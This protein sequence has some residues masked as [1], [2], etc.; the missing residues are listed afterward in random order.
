MLDTHWNSLNQ[1]K[2]TTFTIL[3]CIHYLLASRADTRSEFILEA[4]EMISLQILKLFLF[5]TETGLRCSEIGGNVTGISSLPLGG[6]T[7]VT[8]LIQKFQ[9]R[10]YYKVLDIT[11]FG[12]NLILEAK[13]R[14]RLQL[15]NRLFYSAE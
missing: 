2:V 4:V 9:Q 1:Y 12:F 15:E 6:T 5:G 7:S 13:L 3:Q 10:T 8:A 14:T 11:L